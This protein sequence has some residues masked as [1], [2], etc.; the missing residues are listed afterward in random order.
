MHPGFQNT[1]SAS[2][3]IDLVKLGSKKP[4]GYTVG[5]ARFDMIKPTLYCIAGIFFH[6]IEL[7]TFWRKWLA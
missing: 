2:F 1:F 7:I 6:Q 4:F 5:R 3:R